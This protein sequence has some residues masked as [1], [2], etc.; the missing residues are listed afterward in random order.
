MPV[1]WDNHQEQQQQW[2]R[3]NQSLECYKGQ[4][5]R[6]E[7]EEEEEELGNPVKPSATTS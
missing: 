4:S 3:V 2:I 6:S 1:P 7:E 5:W